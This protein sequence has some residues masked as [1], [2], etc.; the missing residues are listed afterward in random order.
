MKHSILKLKSIE[1]DPKAV[2]ALLT[3]AQPLKKRPTL[4]EYL[5]KIMLDK[6][7]DS[8]GV[9]HRAD[10]DRQIFNR[11]I[12]VGKI[13]RA[14]K[15]TLLQVAIGIYATER[16]TAELLATCGYIF[17]PSSEEEQAFMFCIKHA[18]YDM[19]YVYEALDIIQN[20]PSRE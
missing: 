14:S 2:N 5:N 15:R 3:F 18:Y 10:L 16:E 17:E 7:L 4:S 19:Y 12:Q 11:I 9:Y 1:D 8:P 20:A 13:T 6:H